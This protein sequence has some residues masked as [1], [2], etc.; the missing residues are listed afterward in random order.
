MD[1]SV[2]FFFTHWKIAGKERTVTGENRRLSASN[3]ITVV[4]FNSTFNNISIYRGR[5]FY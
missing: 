1:F 3:D 2:T 4:V 5:Q